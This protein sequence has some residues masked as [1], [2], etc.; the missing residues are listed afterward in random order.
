MFGSLFKGATTALLGRAIRKGTKSL[1]K[2]AVK[3]I[4]RGAKGVVKGIKRQGEKF[5]RAVG[6]TGEVLSNVGRIKDS[7]KLF[8]STGMGTAD[9]LRQ[10][11]IVAGNIYKQ[12]V[13]KVARGQ[14]TSKLANLASKTRGIRDANLT[15]KAVGNISQGVE[16]SRGIISRIGRGISRGVSGA[17]KGGLTRANET[18]QP[19][20]LPVDYMIGRGVIGGVGLI[21]AGGT[22]AGS[23]YLGNK[24]SK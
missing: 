15:K 17:V 2:G 18:L 4:K 24:L 8:K 9:A 20:F 3:G 19:A 21:G 12:G 10:G 16:G 13:K 22:T 11:N 7:V 23:V 6:G 5:Q 1:A 14:A